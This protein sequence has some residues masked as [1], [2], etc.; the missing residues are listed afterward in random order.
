MAQYTTTDTILSDFYIA[1]IA[2]YIL[3]VDKW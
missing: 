3:Q 2:K 1:L